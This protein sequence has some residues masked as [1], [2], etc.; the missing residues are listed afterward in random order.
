MAFR[1]QSYNDWFEDEGY[2]I[3]EEILGWF[4]DAPNCIY[5]ADLVG[6]DLEEFANETAYDIWQS[7]ADDYADYMYDRMKDD[8]LMGD[9]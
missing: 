5:I 4:D 6:I 7:Q 8:E 2:Q 3:V 1:Q 9:D